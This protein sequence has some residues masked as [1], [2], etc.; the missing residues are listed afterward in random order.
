MAV[1]GFFS[2]IDGMSTAVQGFRAATAAGFTIS[3][4]RGQALLTAIGDMQ[5]VL[6]AAIAKSSVITQEPPLGTTPAARV[7]RPFLA[8]IASDPAQGFLPAVK[9]LSEDLTRLAADVRQSMGVYG[10]AEDQ[11]THGI[12]TAGGPI[13]SA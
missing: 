6:E 4:D 10:T 13:H 3:A 12:T 2:G 1:G 8:T 7:Y 11:N 9:K 5:L